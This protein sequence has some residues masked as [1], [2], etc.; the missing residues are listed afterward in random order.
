MNTQSSESQTPSP[1]FESQTPPPSSESQTPPPRF[2]AP[3]P[4]TLVYYLVGVASLLVAIYTSHRLQTQRSEDQARQTLNEIRHQVEIAAQREKELAAQA[5]RE[6]VLALQREER[7]PFLAY[8][9]N[10]RYNND[11]TYVY[12]FV[13]KSPVYDAVI[14][15]IFFIVTDQ[16]ELVALEKLDPRPAKDAAEGAMCSAGGY[17]NTG[18]WKRH[19]SCD[20]CYVF[21]SCIEVIVPKGGVAQVPLRITGKIYGE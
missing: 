5:Q 9:H 8:N 11:G 2:S 21:G 17:F 7:E 14:R 13:N 6:K 19:P 10:G 12:T 3:H 1:S 4:V 15:N 20:Y 16:T 18:C